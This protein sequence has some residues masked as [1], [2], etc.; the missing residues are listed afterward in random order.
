MQVLVRNAVA[1]TALPVVLFFSLSNEARAGSWSV[2]NKTP[3][4]V[5]V[6]VGYS[7][8]FGQILT[9]GWWT[10]QACGGCA[11]VVGSDLA[12]QL[13]DKRNAYLHA[14]AGGAD[15]IEGDENFCVSGN[16]FSLNSSASP[17][18]GSRRSFRQVPIDLNKAWT[19]NITGRSVSGRVCF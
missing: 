8:S 6:A 10:V 1:L 12:N 17:H 4:K 14:H 11:T 18:C 5:T 19:T 13:P 15:V 3:D 7:N 2:C 16:E 9:N